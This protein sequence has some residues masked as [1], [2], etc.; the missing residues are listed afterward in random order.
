MFMFRD[1]TVDCSILL[2]SYSVTTGAL[3]SP[4]LLLSY[5]TTTVALHNTIILII[6]NPT[7]LTKSTKSTDQLIQVLQ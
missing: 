1:M 2:L 5:P 7:K 6:T 3:G 4:D